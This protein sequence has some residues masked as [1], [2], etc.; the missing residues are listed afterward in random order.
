M[1]FHRTTDTRQH[2]K[3]NV[4]WKRKLH[5]VGARGKGHITASLLPLCPSGS[6]CPTP[7][8][9]Q[10]CSARFS[11]P[12]AGRWLGVRTW[13]ECRVSIQPRPVFDRQGHASRPNANAA[14]I[15]APRWPPPVDVKNVAPQP[16]DAAASHC[17]ATGWCSARF[18]RTFEHGTGKNADRRCTS[19]ARGNGGAAR[20]SVEAA[21]TV[22]RRY[23][24]AS[25]R[26]V[27]VLMVRR[28]PGEREERWRR[29]NHASEAEGSLP[30]RGVRSSP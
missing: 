22:S 23:R 16:R 11:T 24:F 2:P 3:S 4:Y 26:R 20:P 1:P 18:R 28:R 14:Q 9:K 27:D 17:E 10:G 25:R 29:R 6:S 19:Y 15:R 21:S 12:S 13:H 8:G 30:P 7:P 5:E